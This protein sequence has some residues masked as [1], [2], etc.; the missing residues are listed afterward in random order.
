MK[1]EALTSLSLENPNPLQIPLTVHLHP[2][3]RCGGFLGKFT[4]NE[5]LSRYCYRFPSSRLSSTPE[6]TFHNHRHLFAHPSPPPVVDASDI[7]QTNWD[8]HT[9]CPKETLH[10]KPRS[11]EGRG[12]SGKW[13]QPVESF[14]VWE[15]WRIYKG[16][17]SSQ[18][19]GTFPP[20]SGSDLSPNS[21]NETGMNSLKWS[22]PETSSWNRSKFKGIGCGYV[23]ARYFCWV[24]GVLGEN[25]N[26][27]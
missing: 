21:P 4:R 14:I 25:S 19:S 16:V 13:Y 20:F 8:R 1:I 27:R 3:F 26:L 24:G 10:L 22:R 5:W 9:H 11:F 18:D 17:N 23:F 6:R 7:P 12:W 2:S 15:T